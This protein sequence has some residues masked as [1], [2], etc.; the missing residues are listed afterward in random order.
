[1]GGR[2]HPLREPTDLLHHPPSCGSRPGGRCLPGIRLFPLGGR[3]TRPG[4][5]G[6][7][8]TP[9]I[10]GTAKVAD[11][12][13]L[14]RRVAAPS[15]SGRIHA[16]GTDPLRAWK[17]KRPPVLHPQHDGGHVVRCRAPRTVDIRNRIKSIYT[18]IG[19][20]GDGSHALFHRARK[21]VAA[22]TNALSGRHCR[23][24]HTHAARYVG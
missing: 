16:G 21:P 15:V 13:V 3:S 22:G 19:C 8:R 20:R 5:D 12:P 23:A 9:H 14:S 6:K 18:F 11:G 4:R 17:K 2:D 7:E 24:H 10:C 1:M